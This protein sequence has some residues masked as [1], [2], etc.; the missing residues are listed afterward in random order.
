VKNVRAVVVSPAKPGSLGDQAM[1]DV[2]VT[3]ASTLFGR[4]PTIL[5]FAYRTRSAAKGIDFNDGIQNRI[6]VLHEIMRAHHLLVVGADM[7][8]GHYGKD[9]IGRRLALARLAHAFGAK[10]RVVGCSFST[11]PDFETVELLKKMPWLDILARD[12]VS[13]RRMRTALGRDIQLVADV[14][15]LLEPALEAAH[16]RSAADWIAQQRLADRLVF[17]VNVSGLVF[18]KLPEGTLE[19][20]A[21]VV[22]NHLARE[23]N[24]AVMVVPHD[25]RPGQ[26]GDLDACRQLHAVLSKRGEVESHL[27]EKPVQAWEMKAI[28]GLV[29]AALLCRM[30]F[31]IACLGQGVPTYCLVSAGKFDGL[32]QHFNLSGNLFNPAELTERA[33][34]RA[35]A[36]HMLTH[37]QADAQKVKEALP[38]VI[39]LSK[40]NFNDLV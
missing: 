28:A 23:A 1:V 34:M 7:L 16:G 8:D 32:M 36:E 14:A 20:F 35:A 31:A 21:D 38:N 9:G 24:V 13:Q 2:L 12:P 3:Q 27:L 5:P 37:W 15:F 39:T 6:R 4:P 10:V 19:N 33:A 40:S 18:K 29:D 25:W 11:N 30:H 26:E 17:A 22:A